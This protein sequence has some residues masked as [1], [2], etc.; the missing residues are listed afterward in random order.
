MN[1]DKFKY[2]EI[3]HI[4][5]R[6]FYEAPLINYLKT[7]KIEDGL[8]LNFGQKP[9]LKNPLVL[10]LRDLRFA[11]TSY[12]KYPRYCGSKYLY[13]IIKEKISVIISV[14]RWLSNY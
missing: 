3:A 1:A 2:K 9:K 4:I 11:P 5:L 7:T 6:S 14:D 12:G 13:M 8:L 10:L